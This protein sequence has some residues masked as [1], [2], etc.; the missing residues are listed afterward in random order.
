MGKSTSFPHLFAPIVIKEMRL[1]N[2]LVLPPMATNYATS[3]GFVTERLIN[4]YVERAKGGVGLI[5]IEAG[6]VDNP[7]GRIL[8]N[9]VGLYSDDHIPGMKKL[10]DAV[11]AAGAS[12]VFQIHHGGK[13]CSRA[14]TG[15]Q[16]VSASPIPIKTR[17]PDW[18][19]GEAP[20]E[21]SIPEIEQ[22]VGRFADAAQRVKKS[23]AD[24]VEIH[25]AHGYLILNFLSPYSNIRTD[26]YGGSFEGRMRFARE[27]TREVR[28]K[29]GQDYVVMFRLSA[30][31]PVEGG[32]RLE[33]SQKIVKVLEKDGVDIFDI[34]SGNH[35]S[36][37]AV[38]PPVEMPNGFRV[39]LAAGIKPLVKVPVITSGRITDPVMAEQILSEG[40]ADLVAMGRAL[41]ADPQLPEKAKAGRVSAIR[42]C[43]GC[44]E[45]C[46]G[47]LRQLDEQ[48]KGRMTCT[49]NPL[50]GKEGSITIEK[51]KDKKKVLV[52]GGGPAGMESA[53]I[54]ASRGHIVELW[55]QS[56][57]LGGQVKLAAIPPYKAE[58]AN[59]TSY[60]TTV[61]AE[62]GVSIKLSQQATLDKIVA[63]K[64]DIIVLALGANPKF[65]RIPGIKS[66]NVISAWDVLSGKA[67]EATDVVVAG[68]GIVGCETA[69]YLAEKGKRV[70]IV[71]M[72]PDIAPEMEPIRRALMRDRFKK[73][74]IEVLV[75]SRIKE[76]K[77]DG[78]LIEQGTNFI[79]ADSV[80]IALGSVPEDSLEM[81]LKGKG[82]QVYKAGDCVEPRKVIDAIHEGFEIASRI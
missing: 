22:I 40:K 54:A 20:R 30:E 1:K 60:F 68:A 80:V 74:S 3:D 82:I 8:V 36:A 19:G 38:I 41:I 63:F 44:N 10:V 76:I 47:R 23:G 25:C 28:K 39:H 24:A 62:A 33:D 17:E 58:M 53:Y 81:A 77:P 65:P 21:L 13:R 34:S 48:G 7:E 9:Q 42:K 50:V 51:A 69:E 57:Q 4:Y 32:L 2:R 45:G 56:W 67:V 27:I 31:E 6:L 16:P 11:H 18:I 72:L 64:P 73:L 79:K 55:E 59:I 14:I 46:I 66:K 78:V 52:I 5:I 49:L 61:L 12:I 15:M 35:D 71:E 29:V 75:N 43:I 37:F 26:R 70:T